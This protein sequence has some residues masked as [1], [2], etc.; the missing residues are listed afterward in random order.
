MDCDGD[1]LFLAEWIFDESQCGTS[2]NDIDRPRQSSN[3]VVALTPPEVVKRVYGI[4]RAVAE[5]FKEFSLHFW[6]S[7]GTTLGAVR[8]RG[9]I[10]WDDDL[11]LC[12]PES[13]EALLVGDVAA[14]LA[15]R[16]SLVLRPANTF[17]YRVV[18]RDT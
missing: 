14:A 6:T 7:G 8:H 3:E 13:E 15:D 17:G 1:E 9:L 11:D 10:P 5:V 16:H 2:V 18:P 4:G 12:V